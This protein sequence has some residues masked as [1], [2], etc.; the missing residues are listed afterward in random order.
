MQNYLIGG[1]VFSVMGL[2]FALGHKKIGKH[3]TDSFNKRPALL[4]AGHKYDSP[5]FLQSAFLILGIS[6]AAFGVM[7][8]AEY[9][10]HPGIIRLMK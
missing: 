5:F 1:A 2:V 8:L 9:F 10:F 4:R 3:A 7:C 6:F